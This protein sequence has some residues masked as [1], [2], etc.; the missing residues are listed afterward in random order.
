M[1]IDTK[2]F[3][4]IKGSTYYLENIGL[5]E[6]DD[7]EIGQYPVTNKWYKEFVKDGGYSDQVLWTDKGWKW[8]GTKTQPYNWDNRAGK[9]HPVVHVTWYEADAFC[10]WLTSLRKDDYVYRLPTEEE[11]QFAAEGIN[12]NKYPWGDE[13][14][15]NRCN[16]HEAGRGRTTRVDKYL[17]G[18]TP[19]DEQRS[20]T[21]YDMVGNVWEWIDSQWAKDNEYVVVRG[22]SWNFDC[23]YC[24]CA[25]R[26]GSHPA[27]RSYLIGFRCARIL[28]K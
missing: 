16:S 6:L 10:K 8:K 7:Y 11:W 14:D 1:K 19:I 5:V 13:W 22:G 27:F 26:Y 18:S 20:E 4:P 3:V 21:I 23:S 17:L 9:Y 2:Q 12:R 25:A 28:N 15:E 24:R